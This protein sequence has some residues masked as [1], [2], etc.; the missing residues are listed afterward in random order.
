MEDE[1]YHESFLQ[2]IKNSEELST[3]KSLAEQGDE[4]AKKAML[5]IAS[6]Y[7]HITL[8]T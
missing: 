7:G 4:T 8:L 3:V 2:D 6:M 1:Q 5:L